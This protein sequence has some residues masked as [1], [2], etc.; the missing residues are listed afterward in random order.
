MSAARQ[1]RDA[2]NGLR[3]GAITADDFRATMARLCSE[4]GEAAY[5]MAKM[6]AAAGDR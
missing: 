3:T 2:M 1:I 4:L 5:T 6:H